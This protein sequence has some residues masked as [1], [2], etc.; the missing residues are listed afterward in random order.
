MALIFVFGNTK[1]SFDGSFNLFR[2]LHGEWDD[3]SVQWFKAVA[4][5]LSLTMLYQI[6]SPHILPMLIAFN[7]CLRRMLDKGFFSSCGG[8]KFDTKKILRTAYEELHIGPEFALNI[9]LG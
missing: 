6:F 1:F 5:Q 4:P 9:R 3:F 8:R 2:I 7:F